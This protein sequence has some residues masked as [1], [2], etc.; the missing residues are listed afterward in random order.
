MGTRLDSPADQAA[1]VVDRLAE[2]YPDSTISLRF[3]DR[4][5][6]LIAVILSA[7]CTDERVNAVTEDLFA[8][9]DGPEDYATADQEEL[10][11]DIS[12]ITYYNNKAGY[13]REACE[14]IAAEHD[15]E[16]PD[17]MAELTDLPGVGRKTAN[18]VLQHGHQL[19]EG[20]VVDTHV[21]RLTRRLGITEEHTPE[22]IERELMDLLPRERWQAF[23]HL[24]ISHGRATCTARNPDCA[25]CVLEDVC[26]SSKLDNG[27][28][29]ASGEAW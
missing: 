28:D 2:A 24:C 5:E 22:R 9:Y 17:T 19:V 26:P 21:Q 18:V 4:L 27:V 13:I 15:G 7:Q 10:A 3:S 6:L 8:K 29:L 11:E 12:S 1:E 23:T 16:V 25:G 14:I 20:V